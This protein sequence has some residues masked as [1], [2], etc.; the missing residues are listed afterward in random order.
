MKL[1]LSMVAKE[2]GPF[3]TLLDSLLK[4]QKSVMSKAREEEIGVHL[5]RCTSSSDHRMHHLAR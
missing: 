1:L 5:F 3:Q 4:R 2:P